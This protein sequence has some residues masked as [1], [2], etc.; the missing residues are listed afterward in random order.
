M[1]EET[2]N[3]V[4]SYRNPQGD[5]IPAMSFDTSQSSQNS[6]LVVGVNRDSLPTNAELGARPGLFAKE[7]TEVVVQFKSVAADTIESE[8]SN[9]EL[10]GML[11]DVNTGATIGKTLTFDNMTGFTGT[12]DIVVQIVSLQDIAT[13]TVP[14]GQ[15]FNLVPGA[16]QHIF[17]GDDT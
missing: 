4:I 6:K 2:G 5:S 16:K 8:E 11:T 12:T 7:D 10:V 13:F 17:F 1:A 15:L 9:L 3:V 14:K